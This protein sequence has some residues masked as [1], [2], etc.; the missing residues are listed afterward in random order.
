MGSLQASGASRAFSD[1][2]EGGSSPENASKQG[3]TV[4]GLTLAGRKMLKAQGQPASIATSVQIITKRYRIT[5]LYDFPFF[6]L[7]TFRRR[8]NQVFPRVAQGL[9]TSSQRH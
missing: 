3:A 6:G 9:F 8:E 7:Q 4:F 1:E 5:T 2:V